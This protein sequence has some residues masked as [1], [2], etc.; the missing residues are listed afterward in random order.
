MT[1]RLKILPRPKEKNQKTNHSNSPQSPSCPHPSLISEGYP[2]LSWVLL[3]VMPRRRKKT[4]MHESDPQLNERFE[5]G[6]PLGIFSYFYGCWKVLQ[7]GRGLS[8]FRNM[9]S[10]YHESLPLEIR[11]VKLSLESI[12]SAVRR[13][14]VKTLASC[15]EVC[16]TKDKKMVHCWK[17]ERHVLLSHSTVRFGPRTL[18]GARR[19]SSLP[20]LEAGSQMDN[21]EGHR[22]EKLQKAGGPA[23]EMSF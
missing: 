6:R 18:V 2:R 22:W 13:K 14:M 8:T 19:S 23:P 12:Y 9:Q 7:E 16:G 3:L 21:W 4:K 10:V 5:L 11:K 20:G 17:E 1:W 15:E